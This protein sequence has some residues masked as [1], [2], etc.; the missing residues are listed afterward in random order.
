MGDRVAQKGIEDKHMVGYV[1]GTMTVSVVV[2]WLMTLL[3]GAIAFSGMR[4]LWLLTY[5]NYYGRQCYGDT[6]T[7]TVMGTL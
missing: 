4:F 3:W 6:L 2:A 7:V 1:L 5:C